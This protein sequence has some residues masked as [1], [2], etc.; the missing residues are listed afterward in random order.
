[1]L[2]RRQKTDKKMGNKKVKQSGTEE[3]CSQNGGHKAIEG[4]I[5]LPVINR[6]DKCHLG[7]VNQESTI[8]SDF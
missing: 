4:F 8:C 6:L 3:V 7:S 5:F 2:H 1:M